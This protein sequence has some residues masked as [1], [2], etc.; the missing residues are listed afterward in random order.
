M[1]KCAKPTIL[2]SSPFSKQRKMMSNTDSTTDADWRL[3]S[4]CAATALTRSFLVTV[5][6][7]LLVE[8]L[9]PAPRDERLVAL[10]LELLQ[11]GHRRR[12]VRERADP[13]AVERLPAVRGGLPRP[14]LRHARRWR[15]PAG[16]AHLDL[17]A[18]HSEILRKR[19]RVAQRQARLDDGA[20]ARR[21]RGES[22]GGQPLVQL[23][24]RKAGDED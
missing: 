21:L 22:L 14:G 19:H 9:R 17:E 2:T 18:F 11:R 6:T 12:A 13:H 24:R 1:R 5:E 7:H 8:T 15:G 4:P 23:G 16:A 20:T 3:L 10:A